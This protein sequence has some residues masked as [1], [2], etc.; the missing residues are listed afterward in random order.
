MSINTIEELEKLDILALRE[1]VEENKS[2][3]EQYGLPVV[4]LGDG[5]EYAIAFDE[6]EADQAAIEYIQETTWAFNPD[7]I[8][9]ITGMPVE[10]FTCVVNSGMYERSNSAILAC[11]N[12]TCGIYEFAMSAIEADGRGHFLSPYDSNEVELDSGAYAYRIN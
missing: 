7:F 4:E 12:M 11:I 2:D 3:W 5:T 6:E 10:I 9:D 8:A 1:Y